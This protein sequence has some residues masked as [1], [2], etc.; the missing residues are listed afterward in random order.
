MTKC[1]IRYYCLCLLNSN[2]FCYYMPERIR[3]FVVVVVVF[4]GLMNDGKMY[5]VVK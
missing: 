2:M 3:F 1:V 4:P 5:F